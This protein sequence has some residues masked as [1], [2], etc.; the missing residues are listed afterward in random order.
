MQLI[1]EAAPL[2]PLT[3]NVKA[4]ANPSRPLLKT[5]SFL[6]VLKTPIA[7][8]LPKLFIKADFQERREIVNTVLSNLCLNIDL[9][10]WK[11]KKP[12]D[13]TALCNENAS[14]QEFV[15]NYRTFA[16]EINCDVEQV[17]ELLNY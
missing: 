2:Y 8:K 15:D 5:A 1:M 10:G 13:T 3:M 9:L 4:A 17:Q 16:A 11:Y 12:F 6:L 14:W 7:N